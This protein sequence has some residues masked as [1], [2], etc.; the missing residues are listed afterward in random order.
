VIRPVDARFVTTAVAKEGYP[1]GG[2]PEIAF[3]GRSNVGKSSMINTLSGR[4]KLVR[5]S[6]TPGRTRTLNFFDVDLVRDGQRRTVRFADLPGYGFAKV[7]KTQ[8]A[9]WEG[10]ITTYLEE[11]RELR[12]VVSIIDAEVGPT[13][14]DVRTLGY[15]QATQ[16]PTLVVATKLDRLAKARRRPKLRA[17]ATLLHIDPAWVLG[18]SATEKLGLTEVLESVWELTGMPDT[19]VDPT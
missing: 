8:R 15:L 12:G 16:R 2:F 14:D 10:M 13:P 18:F 11:R 19:S 4:K 9:T 17:I 5:I 7:Q 1:A 6:N 3:V